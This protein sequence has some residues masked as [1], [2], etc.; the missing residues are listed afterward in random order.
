MYSF[1]MGTLHRGKSPVHILT[2]KGLVLF[3]IYEYVAPIALPVTRTNL[4][5][6]QAASNILLDFHATL[7]EN[8]VSCSLFDSEGEYQFYPI[9]VEWNS[10]IEL[11][12]ESFLQ[13][14]GA[15]DQLM[16]SIHQTTQEDL[17]T[18]VQHGDLFG[19]EFLFISQS[20]PSFHITDQV[21]KA[22]TLPDAN[23]NKAFPLLFHCGSEQLNPV[24]VFIV[25][26]MAP[27]LVGGFVS[28][29]VH[30]L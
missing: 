6:V 4:R 21:F 30:F 27:N 25:G 5:T 8:K 22:I 10:E 3:H 7:K 1:L 28:A 26:K 18:I 13:V 17:A 11:T 14:L 12:P 2:G 19:N 16:A 15:H 23:G 9:L 24:P 29:T 20:N